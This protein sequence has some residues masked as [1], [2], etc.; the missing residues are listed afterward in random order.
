VNRSEPQVTVVVATR[1]RAAIV[2]DAVRCALEQEG[3]ELEIVVVD[4]GSADGTGERLAAIGDPRLR[5]IRLERSAGVAHARNVGAAARRGAWLAFL[6]D[7]DLWSP[8]WLRTALAAGDRTGAGFVYGGRLVVDAARRPLQAVLPDRPEVLRSTLRRHNAVGGPSAA[9]VRAAQFDAVGRF[10]EQ[11]HAFADWD[12]WVRLVDRTTAAGVAELL[13]AYTVHADN[14]HV[15]SPDAM[16]AELELLAR[17]G[18][19]DREEMLHWLAAESLRFGRPRQ[20][21][22]LYVKAARHAHRL[23]NL[24]RA[25]VALSSGAPRVAEPPL[26]PAWLSRWPASAL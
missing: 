17:R 10:D 4:D 16:L 9:I 13:V 12:L 21:A 24:N 2:G 18:I 14:M 22:R 3:A 19:G 5:V 23:G 1:D 8:S 25:R 11:L 6:D 7:D 15:R 20:A 26:A